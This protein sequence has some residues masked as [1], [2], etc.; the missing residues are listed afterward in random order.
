MEPLE[1]ELF[2]KWRSDCNEALT[3]STFLGMPIQQNIHYNIRAITNYSVYT[4]LLSS[5]HLPILSRLCFCSA[6]P[7]FLPSITLFLYR[8]LR[9]YSS[10]PL[11]S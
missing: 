10:L 11:K 5:L 9:L 7:S 2:E 3:A 1:I 4:S 6:R 8:Y